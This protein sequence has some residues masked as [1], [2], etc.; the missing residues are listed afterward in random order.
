MSGHPA[1]WFALPTHTWHR[2]PLLPDPAFES[3]GL[4][5]GLGR[6]GHDCGRQIGRIGRLVIDSVPVSRPLWWR[7]KGSP[8]QLKVKEKM[9]KMT[10][11][12]NQ[13]TVAVKTQINAGITCTWVEGG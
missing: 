12:N 7:A 11:S 2:K 8:D 10:N 4:Q 5:Q 3:P 13:H 9:K 1:L 6:F